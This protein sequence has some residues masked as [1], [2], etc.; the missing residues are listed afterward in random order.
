M[1]IGTIGSGSIVDTIIESID[2]NENTF[3]EAVYSRSLER[4]KVLAERH[5]IKKVYTEIKDLLN[6]KEI[7]FIYV[8]SP[9]SLHYSYTKAALEAGKNVI[10]EKPFTSTVEEAEELIKLAKEKKLFLFEGITTMY[11]PNYKIIKDKLSDLGNIK[12]VTLN[13][14][15]YSS[16]YD[17]FLAGGTPNVF[18]T[19]FSGGALMDINLYNIYFAAGLFGMPEDVMYYPN[20]HKNGIDTSG[21]LVL[22]YPGFVCQCTGAKDT[23]GENFAQI[24]GEKGYFY[25]PEGGNGCKKVKLVTKEKEQ[26]FDGQSGQRPWYFEIKGMEEIVAA[27]DYEQC[28]KRLELTEMVVEILEKARRTAGITFAADKIENRETGIK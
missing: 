4:G 15:Q 25:I 22:K 16:K 24:M 17:A 1:R 26:W 10:C 5:H 7:D 12:V 20:L 18:N 11:L 9:N 2:A 27:G 28:F 13:Y 6:D 21:I 14:C 23:W 8:A 3:C 19:E